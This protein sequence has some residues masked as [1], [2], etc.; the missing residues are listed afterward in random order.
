MTGPRRPFSRSLF[1][2]RCSPMRSLLLN[3][4]GLIAL[5]TVWAPSA[6]A[7]SIAT[8]QQIPT[9][10]QAHRIY[11]TPVAANGDTLRLYTDTGGGRLPILLKPTV[12]G[13][14]LPIRDTVSQGQRSIPITTFPTLQNPPPFP[15]PQSSRV[16]VLPPGRQAQ[17]L[18][19]GD[20]MLGQH[21]F[22]GRRWTFDYDAKR[23]LLH[24]GPMD[25]PVPTHT[26]SLGF[27]TDSTGQRTNNHPRIEATVD[28]STYSFLFDTGATTVLTDSAQAALGGPKRRG[29][30]FVVA[31][32]FDRWREN[33]PEWRVVEGGSPYRKGTPLIRVP[34]VT[35]AGH[36][37]GPV[38]FERRPDRAFQQMSASMDQPVQGALGGSLF[39]Y[40]RITVSYPEGWASFE[41]VR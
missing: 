30:S 25:P 21:W 10:F 39:Q 38:W 33:H 15:Q 1:H 2:V 18:D 16:A 35:I 12:D 5:A 31:S 13:L 23:L 27:Q 11:A 34:S 32:V 4:I 29:S 41:R 22:A 26:A 19:L 9:H 6:S 8:A 37:V 24:E 7:Q 20:G 28:D 3:T 14:D 36:T 40:F 17:L